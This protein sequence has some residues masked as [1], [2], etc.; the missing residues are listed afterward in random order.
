MML[1]KDETW[2]REN[3]AYYIKGFTIRLK[4]SEMLT[5]MDA[6]RLLR[7]D[8]DTHTTDRQKADAMLAEIRKRVLE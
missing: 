7:N 3:S 8:A 6:L 1:F 4:P 2:S 5:I